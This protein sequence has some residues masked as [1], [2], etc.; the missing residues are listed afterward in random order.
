[1]LKKFVCGG[2]STGPPPIAQEEKGLQLVTSID[3]ISSKCKAVDHPLSL[4]LIRSLS[5]T[6]KRSKKNK[7]SAKSNLS[8]PLALCHSVHFRH[9][10]GYSSIS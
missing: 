8:H 5:E 1:M 6:A 10:M 4:N 3:T 2:F 9:S 7:K